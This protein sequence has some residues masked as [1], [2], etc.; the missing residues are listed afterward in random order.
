MKEKIKQKRN[1]REAIE[2]GN[3]KSVEELTKGI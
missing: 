3:E 1:R 2:F